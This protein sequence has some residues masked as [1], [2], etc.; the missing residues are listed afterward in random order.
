MNCITLCVFA[1]FELLQKYLNIN[2]IEKQCI[3]LSKGSQSNTFIIL[4]TYRAKPLNHFNFNTYNFEVY[5]KII[6]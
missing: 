5:F 2:R 4:L 6:N 1:Q 3:I